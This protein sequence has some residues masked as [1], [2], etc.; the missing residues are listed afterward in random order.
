VV[1]RLRE[2]VR[3]VEERA[4]RIPPQD[5]PRVAFL[6][7]VD[8]PFSGG[9]WN[10]KLIEMAG[11][12]DVLGR[13]GEPSRTVPWAEVVDGRPDVLF[14]ACCGF[15]PERALQD[16]PQL[17]QMPGWGVLPCVKAGRVYV[18]DG[19]A[20]FSRPGPRLV[21]SLEILAHALHP[22]VHPLPPGLT[23]AH[24]YDE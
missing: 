3:A 11:G 17:A 8:P 14:V 9:H 20:H 12:V 22:Q 10:P 15:P 1:S 13:A 7:W 6:E 4:G 16:M 23:A 19:N 18:A 24:R 21:D 2:R 5:R